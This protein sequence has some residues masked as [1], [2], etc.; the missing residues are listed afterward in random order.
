MLP[1]FLPSSFRTQLGLGTSF[2]PF[3]L[4]KM[5]FSLEVLVALRILSFLRLCVID[6]P[7]GHLMTSGTFKYLTFHSREKVFAK[8]LVAFCA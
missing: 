7:A 5:S 2:R 6:D 4:G 1:V 3:Q 8:F